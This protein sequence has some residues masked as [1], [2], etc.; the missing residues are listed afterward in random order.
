MNDVM[1]CGTRKIYN[2]GSHRIV[3]IK[4]HEMRFMLCKDYT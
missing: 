2:C 1:N 4:M 3:V